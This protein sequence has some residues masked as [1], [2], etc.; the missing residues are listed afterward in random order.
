MKYLDNIKKLPIG[1]KRTFSFLVAGFLTVLII[2]F[3]Y[4][5]SFLWKD[6]VKDNYMVSKNE[7]I[8]SFKESFD[9]SFSILTSALERNFTSS[10][11]N[12]QIASGLN[13]LVDQMS[14]TSTSS[15]STSSNIV[16]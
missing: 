9:K 15:S 12:Q 5:I 1:E 3:N 8:D 14:S 13:E 4:G 6:E 10:G 2:V 11:T 7:A 16:E